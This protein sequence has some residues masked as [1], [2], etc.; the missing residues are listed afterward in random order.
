MLWHG[1]VLTLAGLRRSLLQS[2]FDVD[3]CNMRA[4]HVG[5]SGVGFGAVEISLL[6]KSRSTF[7]GGHENDDP[8]TSLMF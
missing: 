5:F 3:I 6:L 2:D 8:N 4:L 7:L 1:H